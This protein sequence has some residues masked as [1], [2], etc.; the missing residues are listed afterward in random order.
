MNENDTWRK[1]IASQKKEIPGFRKMLRSTGKKQTLVETGNL[2]INSIFNRDLLIQQNEMERLKHD[3]DEQQ[4]R[5]SADCESETEHKYDIDTLCTQDILRDR[6]KA[7]EKSYIDL[8]CNFMN[9]I[10]T[11]L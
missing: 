9:Y 1:T 3:I 8:K 4:K 2:A 5:L 7:V 10:S 11:L 6:I